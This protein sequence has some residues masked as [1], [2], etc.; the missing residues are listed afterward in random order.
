MGVESR[1]VRLP[2][3][4]YI[5]WG[6]GSEY[7]ISSLES[8]EPV[9]EIPADVAWELSWSHNERYVLV[10]SPLGRIVRFDV[11]TGRRVP[12]AGT[13]RCSP[14]GLTKGGSYGLLTCSLDRQG[15]L[16]YLAGPIE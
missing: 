3:G 6:S 14:H 1:C 8:G 2:R 16:V 10:V 7:V 11:L 15:A 5:A 12:V 13:T 4:T 9:R